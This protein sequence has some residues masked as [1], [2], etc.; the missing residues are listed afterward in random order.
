MS[1]LDVDLCRVAF[2]VLQHDP[3]GEGP[4]VDLDVVDTGTRQVDEE[5]AFGVGHRFGDQRAG[6]VRDGHRNALGEGLLAGF[7]IVVAD[8]AGDGLALG[9]RCAGEQHGDGGR[10][11]ERREQHASLHRSWPPG[12]LSLRC[13]TLAPRL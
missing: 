8:R 6:L 7:R 12:Q 2:G 13:G 4:R 9:Q 1:G 5:H 11:G 10:G 3:G